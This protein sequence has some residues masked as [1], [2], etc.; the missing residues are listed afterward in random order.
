MK[1][2][3]FGAVA[4]AVILAVYLGPL[5]TIGVWRL[6]RKQPASLEPTP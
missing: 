2:I 1:I 3:K 5:L 6:I 4:L